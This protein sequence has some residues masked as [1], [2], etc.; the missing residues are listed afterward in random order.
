MALPRWSYSASDPSST[1]A[2]SFQQ[3]IDEANVGEIVEAGARRGV[4]Q[5]LVPNVVVAAHAV[6]CLHGGGLV[7][8]R[9][10]LQ[11]MLLQTL[12]LHCVSAI[13]RSEAA[14]TSAFQLTIRRWRGGLASR[15]HVVS[16][17]H[18]GAGLHALNHAVLVVVVRSLA[19]PTQ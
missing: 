15:L 9:R 1:R 17:A 8:R 16:I 2:C 18:R 3:V 19:V 6:G 7:R 11:T 4:R 10:R 5:A 13:A 12:L 14:R